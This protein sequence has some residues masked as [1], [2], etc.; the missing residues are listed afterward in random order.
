MGLD[1]TTAKV[2]AMVKNLDDNVGRLIAALKRLGLEENTIL[3][4]MTDNGPQQPRYNA[5]MR[6]RKG[7]VYQGGIR[8]PFFVRWPRQ[9]RA[10]TTVD[11]I[12]AHIDVVPTLLEACRVSPPSGA[13][14]DGVSLLPLARGGAPSWPDRTLYFQWHRGDAPEPFRAAAVRSQRYKLV[15][16]KELYDLE[17]DPAESADIAAAN[18]EIV[19]RMRKSYQAWFQDVSS[20]RGYDPPR[21]FLG[22][23]HEDPVRLTRQDWRGPKAGW[24]ADSAGYWEVDV[25]EG[26]RYRVTLTFKFYGTPDGR[27]VVISPSTITDVVPHGPDIYERDTDNEVPPGKAKQVDYA[28]DGAT[29]FFT[30]LVTRNGETLI[31]E[32]VV[33]KYVPWQAVYRYGPDFIPPEGAIVRN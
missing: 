1:D 18:P 19:A 23:R 9:F 33:S 24:G 5:G 25:R 20:T 28:V 29:V 6:G 4:F 11:R 15:D 26:G 8:V 2:Y 22:T 31:N 16:G 27:Q 10:G 17:K 12:A 32:R 13:G 3:I 14:L 21:I 7:T 30:R